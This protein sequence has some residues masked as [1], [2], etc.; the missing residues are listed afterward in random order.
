MRHF[1]LHNP[2]AG[3][4]H[5]E[6]EL[7]ILKGHIAG[8]QVIIDV[9]KD[10]GYMKE[11]SDLRPDD[12]VTVSGGDGT[13]NRFINNVDVDNLPCDVYYY[14][15]GSGNDFMHDITDGKFSD[16]PVKINKYLKGLPTVY[17]NGMEKRFIN[18]IGYGIDGYCCEVGD[19]KK[20]KGKAVNYTAIAIIGLLFN[21][22]KRN[23]RVTV[24]GKQL[25]FKKVTIAPT[26]K[27]RFYGGGMMPTPAQDRFSG[28]VSFMCFHTSGTLKTLTIFPSLFKGEHVKHTEYTEIIECSEVTV[29]FDTPC[30]LQIDGE[31]VK[32]V[33]KYTVK[34]N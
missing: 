26:M 11:L 28:K 20:E 25:E 4:G 31:T 15:S 19:E 5:P 32:N 23:A 29:E 2:L 34:T 27:G 1:I 18:G 21:Y 14:G 16:K 8:E 7:A 17:V 22:K 24:D 9:T 30:A 3:H 6:S 33:K 10:G 13:L 12:V